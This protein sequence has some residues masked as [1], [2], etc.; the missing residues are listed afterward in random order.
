MEPERWRRIEKLYHSAL[1]VAEDQRATFLQQ[2]CAGDD[3]LR[4][5]VESLLAYQKP[6]QDFIEAPAF[7]MAARLM[8]Q[9]EASSPEADP[10]LVGQTISHYRI[11][12][13][14]GGGGMGVVYKAEDTRLHRF[15]AL[16]FLPNE[17][18]RDSQALA[19][20]RREAEAASALNHP[21]ICTIYD[22]GEENGQ[23]FIAMEFLDGRTLK[24][25]ISGCPIDVKQLLEIGIEVADALDAAHSEGIVHRDIKPANI[26]LTKRGHTKILDFGLAKLM[27]TAARI[28]EAAAEATAG[29]SAENLTGPGS[30]PGTI[31]YMSPEQVRGKELDARTDLFSFGVVL[32]ETATGVLPFRGDTSGLIF[33]AILNRAPAAPVRLNPDLPPKLED[34]INKALEKECALRYQH[35]SEM[36]ADLQRLKRD[37]D[38]GKS[39]A[40]VQERLAQPA[41]TVPAVE[42]SDLKLELE[43]IAAEPAVV[44]APRRLIPF[45]ISASRIVGPTLLIAAVAATWF[46]ARPKPLSGPPT[47]TQLTDQPGQ[48]LYPSLSPDGKSFVYQSRAAGNWDIY[49]QRVGGKNPVNL[50]KDAPEDDRQPAFSPD[51]ER[52][53]FRSEREGGGIFEMG[54]TGENVKR[55][56]SF[57]YNPTW[58]PDGKEIV[59]STGWFLRPEDTGMSGSGQLFRVS[60]ATGEKRLI[61]GKIDSPKQPHWSRHGNRI[62]FWQIP[63]GRRDIWTVAAGGGDPVPV[64]KDQYVDWNPVWSPGGHYLYFSSDRG[65][66]MNLWRIRIDETSGKT[67][68]PPEP[69]TTPS[70]SSGFITFSRDGHQLAYVQQARNWNIYKVGFDPSRGAT[71]GPA[72]PVTQG[73]KEVA[74]P[75]V[76]P[77]GQWIAFTSRL[78]PEDVFV[79]KIDGTGLRQLTDDT[80]ADR[81]P[82]W[83][84]DGKQIAFM[85]NRSGQWQIWTIKPDGSGL[86]Q[87]TDAPAP[88]GAIIPIWSPDGAR[89]VGQPRGGGGMP[90]VIHTRKPWKDQSPEVLP[91]GE[92]GAAFTAWSWSADGRKLAGALLREDG[93]SQGVTVYSL[94]S[95]KYKR[96]APFGEWAHWLPDSRRLIFYYQGKAYLIDSQSR[97]MHEI[98]SLAPHEISW[99][100]GVSRDGRQIVFTLDATEADVWQMNFG[101]S[102][103]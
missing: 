102:T 14:L 1:E 101:D 91:A 97:K 80:Y 67:L 103:H 17:V 8:V 49:L 18:A 30:A 71:V 9:D 57:G 12:Q 34:I 53:A 92:S 58:S 11:L 42:T 60:I 46:L 90:F 31:A 70:P 50:T 65:G 35:A 87:V 96:L 79:V 89:L 39:L 56:T 81:V 5:E 64:T 29:L 3:A 7:Q 61:T 68:A 51:G 25:V 84:P 73:S 15:L 37:I 85:S 98:L 36:R 74:F 2:A 95:H 54:A 86:E 26:F 45:R 66:S 24:H 78:K 43:E 76:S 69:V 21:N 16:K 6:A 10:V 72:V 99:Q 82:R 27:P 44:S 13:K 88:G 93:S 62:A 38:S 40:S 63:G 33:D 28:A 32:Y 77:D 52:I 100:F 41:T 4:Q 83:S 75:D 48:E 59:C 94:D 23:A 55:L 19:R 20:F 22:I 47:F